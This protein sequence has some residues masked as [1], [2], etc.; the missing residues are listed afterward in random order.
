[1]TK[2]IMMILLTVV[3]RY[4]LRFMDPKNSTELVSKAKERY[5]ASCLL[6]KLY[7]VLIMTWLSI[8][9]IECNQILGSCGHL[10]WWRRTFCLAFALCKVLAQGCPQ[11]LILFHCMVVLRYTLK[12]LLCLHNMKK[13]HPWALCSDCQLNYAI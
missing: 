8:F 13:V 6:Y 2:K 9:F 7:M 1:M 5:S 11:S 12:H 10:R 3:C 4:Y